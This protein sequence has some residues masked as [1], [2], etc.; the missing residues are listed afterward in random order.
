MLSHVEDEQ[1]ADMF[2][3]D[4]NV[5]FEEEAT[6]I[7]SIGGDKKECDTTGRIAQAI[8]AVQGTIRGRKSGTVGTQKNLGPPDRS[9]GRS[10]TPMGPDLPHVRLLARRT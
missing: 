3:W 2:E 6:Y 5:A 1:I 4:E 10:Y 7:S 9:K 8:L